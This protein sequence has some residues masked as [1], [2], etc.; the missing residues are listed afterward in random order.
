MY[1]C[2]MYILADIKWIVENK[3]SYKNKDD[4]WKKFKQTILIL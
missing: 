1:I 3:D 4:V 2:K